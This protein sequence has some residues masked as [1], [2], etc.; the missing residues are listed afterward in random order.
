MHASWLPVELV[1]LPS[2]LFEVLAMD[3]S[4]LQLLCQHKDTGEALPAQLA[5][6]LAGCMRAA[7]YSPALHQSMVRRQGAVVATG[8]RSSWCTLPVCAAVTQPVAV[9]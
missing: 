8:E 1:E 5:H 2:T 6:A 3:A 4:A 7:H 9:L